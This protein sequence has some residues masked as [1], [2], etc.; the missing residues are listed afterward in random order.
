MEHSLLHYKE[1]L[2]RLVEGDVEWFLTDD[3][4]KDNDNYLIK[5][6]NIVL[7]KIKIL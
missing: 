1:D 4:S 7:K 5:V 2:I 6:V 3:D